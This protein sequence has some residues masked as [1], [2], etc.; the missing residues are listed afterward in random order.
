MDFPLGTLLDP[1]RCYEFLI[2]VLHPRGLRCPNGH[3]LKHAYVHKRDRAPILDYRCKTCGRC[4][5]AFTGTVFQG[6]KHNAVAVVQILR[7]V[8]QG[9]TTSQLS[10]EMGCSYKWLLEWRHKLQALAS[11]HRVGRLW[12]DTAV[13]ADEMYQNSGEKRRPAP[14]PGRPPASAR[15]QGGGARHVG[16]RPSAGAGAGG[17][18]QPAGLPEGD[19]PRGP[20]RVGTARAQ[21]H[22]PGR[23]GLYR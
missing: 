8:W 22:A 13:E 23:Q 5:N 18:R 19:P 14:R 2:R 1:C 20:A 11:D 16:P 15:Q 12:S 3:T 6:T 10:R 17:A 9:V 4:F 21:G 7:G